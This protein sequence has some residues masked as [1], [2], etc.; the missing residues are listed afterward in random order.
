MS[1]SNPHPWCNVQ[2][3]R[4]R[5]RPA[6]AAVEVPDRRARRGDPRRR[7]RRGL[8]RSPGRRPLADGARSPPRAMPL[9][10]VTSGA[11]N[12]QAGPFRNFSLGTAARTSTPSTT[13]SATD[14]GV[15][16]F[17]PV[18][19]KL[20]ADALR[21]GRPRGQLRLRDGGASSAGRSSP[22]APSSARCPPRAASARATGGSV[23]F[24]G[25]TRLSL[26]NTRFA[27]RRRSRA[28]RDS[29]PAGR[30]STRSS[31]RY[32]ARSG[33][34]AYDLNAAGDDAYRIFRD[35]RIA[36]ISMQADPDPGRGGSSFTADEGLMKG[37]PKPPPPPGVPPT[38]YDGLGQRRLPARAG[39]AGARRAV[40]LDGLPVGTERPSI[41]GP[42]RLGRALGRCAGS[43]DRRSRPRL[44]A[45][46]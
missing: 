15:T 9:I 8:S 13:G 42:A 21:P 20:F 22:P 6:R 23:V 4:L 44:E 41:G 1:T 18:F 3:P 37:T 11:D 29:T 12:R 45:F 33:L 14:D 35:S 31:T 5:R 46:S 28:A 40:R 2:H 24:F 30:S 27:P 26:P 32:G 43:G 39:P 36:A 10:F 16:T 25:G 34:A 38:V 19:E 7:P 17:T